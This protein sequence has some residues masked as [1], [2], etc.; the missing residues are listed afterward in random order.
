MVREHMMEPK[1]LPAALKVMVSD[2]YLPG[3]EY[4]D[5]YADHG[6]AVFMLMERKICMSVGAS[7]KNNLPQLS[8]YFGCLLEELVSHQ[9]GIN[10]RILV[11]LDE[12]IF[13]E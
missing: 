12:A 2:L 6:T 11:A 3:T 4:K 5:E 8:G 1:E 10:A 13:P 7:I 9:N